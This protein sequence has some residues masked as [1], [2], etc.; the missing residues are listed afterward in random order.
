MLNPLICHWK[1]LPWHLKPTGQSL[2]SP[3][4]PDSSKPFLLPYPYP[5]QPYRFTSTH[6][7]LQILIF[8]LMTRIQDLSTSLLRDY[9]RL[10]N[11][12]SPSGRAH[13]FLLLC[14]ILEITH[15][16]HFFFHFDNLVPSSLSSHFCPALSWCVSQCCLSGKQMEQE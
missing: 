8:F 16:Q 13:F 12:V 3:L 7:L 2:W 15:E 5:L 11:T 4:T 9:S 1:N 10:H 14:K 6:L